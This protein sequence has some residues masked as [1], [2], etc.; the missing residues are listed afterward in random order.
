MSYFVS[1]VGSGPS[2]V[3]LHGWTHDHQSMQPLVNWL[4]SEYQLTL[5]D[6]PGM[7]KSDWLEGTA[8]IYDIANQLIPLLPEQ[9]IYIGWSFGGLVTQAIAALHSEKVK[10]IIGLCT[11]PRFVET[12]GWPAVPLP[13][14]RQPF[15]AEINKLGLIA[16]LKNFYQ[17]EFNQGEVDQSALQQLIDNAKQHEINLNHL[18]AGMDICDE[19]D[20]RVEL[21]KLSCPIDFIFGE[22]DV[23]VPQATHSLIQALNPMINCHT[24]SNAQ[25]MPHWTHPEVCRQL[26]NRLLQR[27][28]H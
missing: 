2:V 16:F 25:H 28:N 3:I 19:T 22:H 14:F 5:I 10:Q 11:T 6:L 20:L 21:S 4:S 12:T 9:A 8:T 24:I 18:Y 27:N 26:I 7:G 15:E 13:G 17:Q 1:Q 23:A